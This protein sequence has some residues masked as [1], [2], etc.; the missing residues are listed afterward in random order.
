MTS[1]SQSDC[2]WVDT[3]S[4]LVLRAECRAVLIHFSSSVVIVVRR[5]V[6]RLLN[7]VDCYAAH[8]PS[9][10]TQIIRVPCSESRRRFNPCNASCQFWS[11]MVMGSMYP[12][13]AMGCVEFFHFSKDY[14]ELG[15]WHS[16]CGCR[17][18]LDTH[19]MQ[20]WMSDNFGPTCDL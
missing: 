20:V 12:R 8:P 10:A 2:F 9:A 5:G 6:E 3:V 17:G 7:R 11:R 4:S 15:Q 18:C 13:I 1:K 14:V 19:K 16:H